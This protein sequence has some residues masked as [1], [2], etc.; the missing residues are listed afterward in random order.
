MGWGGVISDV[1]NAQIPFLACSILAKQ[2]LRLCLVSAL[3]PRTYTQNA[4]KSPFQQ[5]DELYLLIHS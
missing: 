4:C 2:N 3:I 5:F 1:P